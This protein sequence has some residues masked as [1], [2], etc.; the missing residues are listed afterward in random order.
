[1]QVVGDIQFWD[2]DAVIFRFLSDIS[3]AICNEVLLKA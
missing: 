2:Q 1:M 3:I